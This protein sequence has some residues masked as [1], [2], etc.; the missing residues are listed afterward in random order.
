ML[1]LL[2]GSQ[3]VHVMFHLCRKEMAQDLGR[4]LK[5]DEHPSPAIVNNRFMDRLENLRVFTLGLSERFQETVHL[6][7][8]F[9]NSAKTFRH[10]LIPEYKAHRTRIKE[11]VDAVDAAKDAA[12]LSDEWACLIA[13]D[14]YEADDVLASIARQEDKQRVLI[15]SP[16]KDMNQ[17]L[18]PERV[19]IIK[20]SGM[21]PTGKN[22]NGIPLDSK[23]EVKYYT[24][25]RFQHEFRFS[26][27]RWVDYQCM[28]GDVADNVRGCDRVGP[29]MAG[30]IIRKYPIHAL[31][32][33]KPIELLDIPGFG[34]K[35]HENWLEFIERYRRL[36]EVFQLRAN[37]TYEWSDLTD[38]VYS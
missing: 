11:V 21:I 20:R 28:V 8:V 34:N 17:C 31:D 16:D 26:V 30:A 33:I 6:A 24:A 1:F 7:V 23:I 27:Q 5:D 18:R 29:A 19:G 9:D 38:G 25:K 36:Y 10:T 32:E 13:P 22:K 2:D 4:E 35:M 14:G 3:V 15:H 12:A 37:L